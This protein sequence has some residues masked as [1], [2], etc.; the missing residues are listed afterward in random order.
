MAWDVGA[1][2]R[3]ARVC[4]RP[5]PPSLGDVWRRVPASWVS[6]CA[7][8]LLGRRSTAA[9]NSTFLLVF[10]PGHSARDTHHD[11]DLEVE[12][13]PMELSLIHI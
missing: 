2:A 6:F 5:A 13:Y 7:Y 4:H 8:A 3:W 9:S 1:P 12:N 11:S 10:A